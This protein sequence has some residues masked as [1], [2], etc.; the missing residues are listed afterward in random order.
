MKHM[1]LFFEILGAGCILYCLSILLFTGHGTN[2]FLIWGLAGILF[3]LWARYESKLRGIMPVW[4]KKTAC[5]LLF[6]GIAVFVVV[7]GMV[8]SGF[9]KKGKE[10]LDYILVLGAQLKESGPSYVLQQRLDAAYDYLSQN[11][12]TMVIVSGGQGGNE[13]DT[14]AQGMYDYLVG[15]GIAPERIIKEDQSRNTYENISFSGQLFDREEVSIG[16]VT[17]NFHVFRALKLARAAGYKD[18]CGIAA[19]SH[20]GVLPNNM[21]REF[22]G[23]VKDFLVG[24]MT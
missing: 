19:R 5:V 9:F 1:K 14:E 22:F 11:E 17:S 3:L 4:F 23:I 15:R 10:G 24:N 7:E 20:V 8:L 21:L 12:N 2:F 13:P 16:I 6:L 18:V